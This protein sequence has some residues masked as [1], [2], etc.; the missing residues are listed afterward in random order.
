MTAVT[1]AQIA[2]NCQN[3][4][5]RNQ[6]LSDFSTNTSKLSQQRKKEVTFKWQ[7][8]YEVNLYNGQLL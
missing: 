4:E 8:L 7:K 3:N 5:K 2:A 6:F 1:A